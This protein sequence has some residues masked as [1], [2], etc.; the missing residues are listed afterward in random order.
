MFDYVLTG[1]HQRAKAKP[2]EILLALPSVCREEEK[3]RE[4]VMDILDFVGLAYRQ[5]ELGSAFPYGG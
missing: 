4:L 3:L 2:W 1:L 5:N